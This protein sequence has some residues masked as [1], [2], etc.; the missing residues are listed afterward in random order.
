MTAAATRAD[1]GSAAPQVDLEQL[2]A[3]SD[4]GGR[5]PIGPVGKLLSILAIAWSLFQLWYA[6]PL[7]YA[8]GFGVFNDT[9]ARVVHLSFA[10]L[11]GFMAYPAFKSSPRDHVPLVDWLLAI[12]GVICVV[13]LIAF[14]QELA[15]RPGLPTTADIVVS[16]VGVVPAMSAAFCSGAL[17]S[18]TG[19]SV[20]TVG[21][22]G[23]VIARACTTTGPAPRPDPRGAWPV[24]AR[25]ARS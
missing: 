12:G 19:R 3:E 13:Y 5:R 2:V 24:S 16:G 22:L 9:E 1:T 25:A 8:L 6:S 4:L 14:Y 7:P 20:E 18:G 17:S 11:L 15:L 21:S 23:S 10:L